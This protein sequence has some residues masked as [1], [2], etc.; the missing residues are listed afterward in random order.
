MCQ[1]PSVGVAEQ[2][3]SVLV[4]D[5]GGTEPGG[6]WIDG[7]ELPRKVFGHGLKGVHELAPQH[8]VHL[9]NG[10]LDEGDVV[11]GT[12]RDSKSCV[13]SA[14]GPVRAWLDLKVVGEQMQGLRSPAESIRIQDE[15]LVVELAPV[16]VELQ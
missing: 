2:E 4:E 9:R 6:R 1:H 8:P 16:V 15:E 13:P 10:R 11:N 7:V 3:A 12:P 5:I 14:Y